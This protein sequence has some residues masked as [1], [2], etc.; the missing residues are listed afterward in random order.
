MLWL[1]CPHLLPNKKRAPYFER[2]YGDNLFHLEFNFLF[3]ELL[4]MLTQQMLHYLR[5]VGLAIPVYFQCASK[6]VP[7]NH[8]FLEY[9][10]SK[11]IWRLS[12]LGFDFD[13]SP[14]VS[15][16]SWIRQWVLHS[17]NDQEIILFVCILANMVSLRILHF[18]FIF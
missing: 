10:Y 6:K 1:R 4:A 14:L 15:F 13:A 11:R 5:R 7:L 3:G 8:L 12:K 17:S 2:N 16:T 18:G 9:E